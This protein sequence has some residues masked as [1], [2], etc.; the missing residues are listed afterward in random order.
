MPKL[1]ARFTIKNKV[2]LHARPATL[3]VK[4]CKKFKSDIIICKDGECRNAKKILEVLELD[5]NNGDEILL[6]VNGEDAEDALRKLAEMI[7]NKFGEE[8]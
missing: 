5:V 1:E 6:I 7:E 2:G 8:D 4:T 3:F